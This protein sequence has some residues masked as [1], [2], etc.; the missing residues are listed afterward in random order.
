MVCPLLF[1]YVS[2][3]RSPAITPKLLLVGVGVSLEQLILNI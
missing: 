3:D 2:G 1:I